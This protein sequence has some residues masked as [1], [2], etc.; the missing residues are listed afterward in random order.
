V[1]IGEWFVGQWCFEQGRFQEAQEWLQRALTLSGSVAANY[2]SIHYWLSQTDC[3]LGQLTEA[4]RVLD[5]G[6]ALAQTARPFWRD[7]AVRY[8]AEA[9]LALATQQWETAWAFFA[10]AAHHLN[11]L[12]ARWLEGQ[13]LYR[14]ALAHQ[15]QGEFEK[16]KARLTEAVAIFT[17]I[18]ATVDL[19]KAQNELG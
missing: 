2:P 11:Q 7:E 16:A 3:A 19:Q 5:E 6:I 8:E 13:L 18:G 14:W 4:R 15:A 10:K 9:G 12:G 1:S 17:D